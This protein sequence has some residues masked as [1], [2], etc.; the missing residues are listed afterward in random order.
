MLTLT[1]T[2]AEAVRTLVAGMDVDDETGGLR[3]SSGE[4]TESGQ[5]LALSLV[6]GPEATDEQVDERG[7]HVFLEPLVTDYLDDKVLDASVDS[8]RVQFVIMD[9]GPFGDGR[10]PA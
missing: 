4:V 2:A 5:S 9:R 8:G 10:A 3:I 1:P 7:V 6:N